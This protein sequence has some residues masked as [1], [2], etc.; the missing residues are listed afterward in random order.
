MAQIIFGAGLGLVMK[1]S[2]TVEFSVFNKR[3][4]ITGWLPKGRTK[5]RVFI[6]RV[7]HLEVVSDNHSEV[8]NSMDQ[9]PILSSPAA[10]LT[11]QCVVSP[12]I[13]IIILLGA[14]CCRQ[15]WSLGKINDDI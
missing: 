1:A 6:A 7:T 2:P 13:S 12:I 15:A 5:L 8:V 14:M 10:N 11:T 3:V 9:R 4:E